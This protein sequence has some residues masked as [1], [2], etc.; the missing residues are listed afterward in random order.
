MAEKFLF[1]STAELHR[2]TTQHFSYSTTC[3]CPRT[4]NVII[5]L[6]SRVDTSRELRFS[7]VNCARVFGFVRDTLAS[8]FVVIVVVVLDSLDTDLFMSLIF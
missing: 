8:L 4:F 6:G 5:F 1:L 2:S 3:L 7:P